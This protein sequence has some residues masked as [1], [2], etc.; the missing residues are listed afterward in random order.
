[1]QSATQSKLDNAGPLRQ[2][3]PATACRDAYLSELIAQGMLRQVPGIR[4]GS[5]RQVM[6]RR[7]AVTRTSYR[8]T[9]IITPQAL[10]HP[11]IRHQMLP[12]GVAFRLTTIRQASI[13]RT[14]PW[15]D[16][17][18]M[19]AIAWRLVRALA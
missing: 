10:T 8:A 13:D 19:V 11:S 5:L 2:V 9:G 12:S 7:Q 3:M 1:M 15:R 16:I 17:I 4:H 18:V 6:P 14:R